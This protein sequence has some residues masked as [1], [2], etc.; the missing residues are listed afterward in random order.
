ME[1][2]LKFKSKLVKVFEKQV[3]QCPFLEVHW[4]LGITVASFYLS[5]IHMARQEGW[6]ELESA[7]LYLDISKASISGFLDE[8]AYFMP[9]ILPH[10][11]KR[12][13]W[14]TLE[15]IPG[16]E[17]WINGITPGTF[18]LSCWH[19]LG[20]LCFPPGLLVPYLAPCVVPYP[21]DFILFLRLW[22]LTVSSLL[23]LQHERTAHAVFTLAFQC[24]KIILKMQ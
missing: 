4:V 20:S 18:P 6:F 15:S 14:C 11:L 5:S 16:Q 2:K 23:S 7:L 9:M 3:L 12:D 24:L 17:F 1:T 8:Y 13:F 21:M 19:H 10:P 22:A